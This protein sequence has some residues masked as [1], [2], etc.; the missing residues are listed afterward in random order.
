MLL[1]A[2]AALVATLVLLAAGVWLI[3]RDRF[4]VRDLSRGLAPHDAPRL[5]GARSRW[6]RQL[7]GTRPG[8]ALQVGL[9]EYGFT[10]LRTIDALFLMVAA[11]V[12]L[13]AVTGQLLSWLLAPLAA[14]AVVP[15]VVGLVRRRQNRRRERFIGQ[16][17]QLARI[18]SNATNAGLSIRTAISIAADE[19]PE[20]AA[21]EMARVA[22]KLGIGES[23]D[24]A[25][26]DLERRLPAR[27]VAV[28][29][30][31]LVVSSRSGGSLITSLRNIADTLDERK[32]TRREVQTMLAEAR[33]TAFLIPTIGLGS[34]FLLNT[35][36]ADAIDHM[37]SQT[38]GKLIFAV[39]LVMYTI[40]YLVFRRVTRVEV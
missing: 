36:K 13:G 19:M 29:V 22:Y 18:L 38:L 6:D 30:S 27:E 21:G 40:G 4:L 2:Y 17:P 34:L 5:H 39:A 35:V 26:D 7:T 31:T 33:S 9:E 16:M 14:A 12:A 15:T 20:P 10:G 25:L 24:R 11:A 37:L 23:L 8:A 28:L 3:V 32:Q 1:A